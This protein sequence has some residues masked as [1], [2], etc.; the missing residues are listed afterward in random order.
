MFLF[1]P[2]W[3]VMLLSFLCEMLVKAVS[4]LFVRTKALN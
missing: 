2:Q 3:A 4:S 1:F